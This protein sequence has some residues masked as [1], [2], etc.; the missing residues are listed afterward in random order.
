MR[1]LRFLII[2]FLVNSFCY[3]ENLLLP[4]E[5]IEGAVSLGYEQIANFYENKP[6]MVSPC[7]IYGCLAGD[8][9]LSALFWAKNKAATKE[10]ALILME[11][12]NFLEKGTFKIIYRTGN[13]PRGLSI[14]K[15]N[16]IELTSFHYLYDLKRVG[17]GE[18]LE[19]AILI[20]DVYDGVGSVFCLNNGK[21]MIAQYD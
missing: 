15:V 17:K 12:K 21:W 6:G 20:N 5:L 11:K 3:A 19:S 10:Y 4:E 2:L 9:E 18:T 16:K 14:K 13:F 1:L 7:Y 8:Q